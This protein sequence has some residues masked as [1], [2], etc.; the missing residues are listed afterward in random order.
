MLILITFICQLISGV[1]V[2]MCMCVCVRAC[3]RVHLCVYIYPNIY[4]TEDSW[5]MTLWHWMWKCELMCV[6][7]LELRA[8]TNTWQILAWR[9]W[10][11]TT[12][13]AKSR[14][15]N[16]RRHPKRGVISSKCAVIVWYLYASDFIAYFQRFR[17]YI[18][19]IWGIH[20]FNVFP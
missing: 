5:Q 9:H 1:C 12:W 16:I 10:L 8:C 18:C 15:G 17:I 19:N 4:L 11:N 7:Y 13:Q 14:Y 6:Y 3:V 2:C 20:V